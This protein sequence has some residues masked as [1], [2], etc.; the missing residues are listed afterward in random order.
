[1]RLTTR[2]ATVAVA[3]ALAFAGMPAAA[4]YAADGQT[5]T[6]YTM[7]DVDHLTSRACFI[8]NGDYVSAKDNYADGHRA[9]AHW[10]T[11]Y[12]RS[13]ECHNTMGAGWTVN[14]DYDFAEN[15]KIRSSPACRKATSTSTARTGRAGS[16]SVRASTDRHPKVAGTGLPA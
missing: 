4:A 12:G 2:S 10:E 8:G 16:K 15:G 3:A 13:G 9:V 6:Y 5:C 11:D 7:D 1:M 14:C